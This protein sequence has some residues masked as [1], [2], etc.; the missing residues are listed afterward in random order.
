VAIF[1]ITARSVQQC[2]HSIPYG[3]HFEK[4]S[5][6]GIKQVKKDTN[7]A[8]SAVSDNDSDSMDSNN[9]TCSYLSSQTENENQTVV[10]KVKQIFANLKISKFLKETK[11]LPGVQV[12][13]YVPDR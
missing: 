8:E 4:E 13:D 6:P 7:E 5:A 1:D 12:E 10:Y 9:S 11:G 3:Y 2:R